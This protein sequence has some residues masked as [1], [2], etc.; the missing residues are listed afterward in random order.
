MPVTVNGR[1]V[2]YAIANVAASQ[3][4]SALVS[5]VSG[6]RIRVLSAVARAGATTTNLTFNTK[7]GGAGTAISPLFA[8]GVNDGP[9]IPF[10]PAGHFVT[11]RGEGLSVTTG[12]GSATGILV[13]YIED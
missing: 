5:A 11:V 4:D 12:A 2:K 1:E 8:S 6:A 10:S 13:A 9:V 3:T 7:P